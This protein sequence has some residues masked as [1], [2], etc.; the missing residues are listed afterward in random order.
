MKLTILILVIVIHL[1]PEAREA[2]TAISEKERHF[3]LN[4]IISSYY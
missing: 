3:S 2:T 4:R 1:A